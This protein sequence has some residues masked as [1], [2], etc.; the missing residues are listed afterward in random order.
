MDPTVPSVADLVTVGGASVVTMILTEVLKRAWKPTD[1]EAGR[2]LPL[3]AILIGVLVAFAGT[4]AIG[5]ID[6]VGAVQAVLTGI[7]AGVSAS[8]LY[9]LIKGPVLNK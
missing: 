2:F 3:I 1:D 8:G 7:F 9:D 6:R 5:A 4:W